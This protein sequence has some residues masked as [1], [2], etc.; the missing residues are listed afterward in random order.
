[1]FVAVIPTLNR[2]NRTGP[3]SIAE[4]RSILDT[5]RERLAELRGF[6]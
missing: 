6:L 2:H 3:M 4:I 1:L 5:N